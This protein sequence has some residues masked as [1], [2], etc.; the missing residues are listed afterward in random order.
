MPEKHTNIESENEAQSHSLT[1]SI[2]HIL[3]AAY[4]LYSK[5]KLTLI[6][7]LLKG[8][9]I[10]SVLI[11][12]SSKTNAKMV[13][14][15]LRKIEYE[16]Y[17]IHEDLDAEKREI[18]LEDFLDKEFHI[19]VISDALVKEISLEGIKLIINYDAPTTVKDYVARISQ[20]TTG[21]SSAVALTLVNDRGQKK[22][23]RIEKA[24]GKDVFK[25]PLPKE[26]NGSVQPV[27]ENQM[28]VKK[29]V[30]RRKIIK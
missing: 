15:E 12:T 25:I 4:V 14:R 16:A 1:A 29:K 8:K 20:N 19:L 13:A 7:S 5:D 3:Q 30:K 28:P 17:D 27:I 9:E 6:H 18:L 10:G 11:F 22:F 23:Q 24:L 2:D 26:L 21:N